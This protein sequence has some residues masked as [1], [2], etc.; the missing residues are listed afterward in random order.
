MSTRTSDDEEPSAFHTRG[1]QVSDR[2]C[3]SV[4][5]WLVT[6]LMTLVSGYAAPSRALP[7]A[8]INPPTPHPPPLRLRSPS[9]PTHISPPRRYPAR[10]T[11]REPQPPERSSN[12]MFIL[13]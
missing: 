9:S 10:L 11:Q 12:L 8:E 1:A 7:P 13:P 6:V 2:T 3:R 4:F 5:L